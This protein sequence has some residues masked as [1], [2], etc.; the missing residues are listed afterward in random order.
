MMALFG[1]HFLNK[2]MQEK[3]TEEMKQQLIAASKEGLVKIYELNKSGYAGCNR[4]GNI[5]DRREFPDA[6]PVQANSLFNIPEPKEWPHSAITA[7]KIIK[8]IWN[9]KCDAWFGYKIEVNMKGNSRENAI[10]KMKKF[11]ENEDYQNV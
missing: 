1:K 6:V 8:N 7:E 4:S 3:M 10:E 11:L 2:I 9:A 5:V